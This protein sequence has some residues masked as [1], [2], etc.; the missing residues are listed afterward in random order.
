MPFRRPRF[1][2]PQASLVPPRAPELCRR[3]IGVAAAA[4]AAGVG[5]AA[6]VRRRFAAGVPPP[7]S[8]IGCESPS[9]LGRAG[10]GAAAAAA[11]EAA[12]LRRVAQPPAAAILTLS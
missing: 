6:N 10:L 4:S 2:P 3:R 7:G 11:A 1:G 5:D 12:V 8:A 9:S